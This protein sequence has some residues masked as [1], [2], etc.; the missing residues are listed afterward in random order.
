MDESINTLPVAGWDIRVVPSMDAII[1]TPS[2]LANM[3]QRADEAIADR[4]FVM[5]RSQARELAEALV[6][7]AQSLESAGFHPGRDPKH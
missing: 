2:F 3:T 5:Y 6:R 7:A 1:F 4:H